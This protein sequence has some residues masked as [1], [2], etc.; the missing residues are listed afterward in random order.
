[1]SGSVLASSAELGELVLGQRLGGEQ[2]EHTTVRLLHQ[3]LEHREVVAERLARR[4]RGHDDQVLPLGDDLERLGLVAVELLHAARAERFHQPRIERGGERSEDGSSRLEAS[5]G[6]DEGAGLERRQELIEE[7]SDRHGSSYVW[8]REIVNI[9][10]IV[11]A[12]VM[13]ALR[14]VPPLAWTLLIAWLSTD[15]WSATETAAFLLPL[16]HRL[17]PWATPDQIDALHWL[18]RKGAHVSEYAVLAALWSFALVR[19]DGAAPLARAARS[20]RSS[21]RRSMSCSRRPR[22]RGRR[23]RPTSCS[24]RQPRERHCSG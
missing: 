12:L 3:G 5:D 18:I 22:C 19:R 1:M 7:L 10:R 15:S 14:L 16:L 20:F 13:R 2:I 11:Q 9:R 4:R 21:R 8:Y 17:I 6:G 23:A 24:I